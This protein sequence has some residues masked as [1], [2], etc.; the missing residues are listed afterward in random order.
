MAVFGLL[1]QANVALAAGSGTDVDP[2]TTLEDAYTVTSGRY[3]FNLGS[4]LFQADVDNSE[5]GGWLLV[6]QYLHQGGTNPA[7]NVVGAASDLPITSGAPLGTDESADLTRWGHAGNAAMS[8]FTGDIEFRW[9]GQTSTHARTLHFKSTVGD[10]YV[11]TGTGSFAGIDTNFTPLSGHD[12]NLPSA[13][14]N[15]FSNQGNFAFTEI[16]YFLTGTYHWSIRGQSNRWAVDDIGSTAADTIHRVWVRAPSPIEV[17]NTNDTGVGSLRDA[18]TFANT[19]AVPDD[20]TFNIPGA[21][22][23][24]I[25]LLSE[26]PA[27][28]DDGITID[29]STQPGASCGNLWSGSGHTLQ[30][31]V[32]GQFQGTGITLS[33]ND[34]TVRGLSITGISNGIGSYAARSNAT[35]ECN[36]FGV[37]P[38]GTAS[39]Q[40][41]GSAL[42]HII[43]TNHSNVVI[44]QN[45]ISNGRQYGLVLFSNSTNSIITNNFIGTN[46]AGTAP[47]GNGFDAMVFWSGTHSVNSFSNNIL[48]GGNRTGLLL[49]NGSTVTGSS[50]NALFQGN[51]IGVDR[52]GNTALG[53]TSNGVDVRAGTTFQ[54]AIFGGTGTDDGN[55]VSANGG[56][57]FFSDGT[58]RNV[59]FLGNMFGVGANGTTDLGNTLRGFRAV[60]IL[61]NVNIGNGTAAGRNVF[62]GNAQHGIRI[63]QSSDVSILGNHIGVTDSGNTAQSNGTTGLTVNTPSS[64]GGHT[65][66]LIDG[67]VISANDNGGIDITSGNPSGSGAISNIVITNNKIGVGA[68]GTTNLG[69]TGYGIKNTNVPGE[70]LVQSNT[71]ANNSLDGVVLTTLPG[72]NMAILTN[73]IFNNGQQG[74]DFNNG[75]DNPEGDGVT[76]NDANDADTGPNEM[77]NFPVING[78]QPIGTGGAALAYD[79]N[80]DAPANTN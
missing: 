65:N 37:T 20:V 16:P 39:T 50:G 45:V 74:I 5:G 61:D 43:L 24:T 46:P 27:L 10:D 53:N 49:F 54:N 70:I 34:L 32:E 56:E 12:A 7:L 42:R 4:G 33:A 51:H 19:H 76:P 1:A 9:F 40:F 64:S 14:A 29:G 28:T 73:A 80:L 52:T 18:I 77:L 41:A 48:S 66:L 21:G 55:I 15:F 58:T 2:F 57:G 78:L 69:N 71:I 30:V 35:I 31:R 63:D 38:A 11:R 23:H 17:R 13:T 75:A 6:L 68:D 25:T 44:D 62:S 8:Q 67:N 59:D 3:Y 72:T 60:G 47:I 22:P 36:Y 26:L 79:F